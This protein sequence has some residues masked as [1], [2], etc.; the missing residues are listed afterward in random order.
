MTEDTRILIKI[1]KRTINFMLS[2]LKK[3]EREEEV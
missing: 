2:L 3:W 1:F